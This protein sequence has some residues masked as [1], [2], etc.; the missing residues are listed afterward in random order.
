MVHKPDFAQKIPVLGI[1]E[2]VITEDVMHD[3]DPPP[4]QIAD[5]EALSIFVRFMASLEAFFGYVSLG[6]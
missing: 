3:A 2:D 6:L 1:P 4:K 5:S